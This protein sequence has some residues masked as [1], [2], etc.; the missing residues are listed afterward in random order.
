MGS[1]N[2]TSI[3]CEYAD[4]CLIGAAIKSVS[5]TDA[6]VKAAKNA[7]TIEWTE[8]MNSKLKGEILA[9]SAIHGFADYMSEAACLDALAQVTVGDVQ[10]AAKK[11]SSGKLSM[12]AV[13]N[14]GT[15]PYLDTL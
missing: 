9:Y 2:V 7:L 12:G 14:L 4:A 6:E 8:Q 3:I 11:V 15:V 13:G 5:V 10:A 1:A